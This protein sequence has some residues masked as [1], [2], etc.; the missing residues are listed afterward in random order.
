MVVVIG[1]TDTRP[2]HS[3]DIVI[4]TWSTI[5][6]ETSLNHSNSINCINCIR[7][8]FCL[9][10]QL[11][12]G[13]IAGLIFLTFKDPVTRNQRRSGR[14]NIFHTFSGLP[15]TKKFLLVSHHSICATV[16]ISGIISDLLFVCTLLIIQGFTQLLGNPLYWSLYKKFLHVS[17]IR[18][19][20]PYHQTN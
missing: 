11:D 6:L 3:T 18:W 4:L 1:V 13:I 17:F 9:V 5:S 10:S 12:T 16:H 15:Q 19:H 2:S 14:W 20:S 8:G 7:K